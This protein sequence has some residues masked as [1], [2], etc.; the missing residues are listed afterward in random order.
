MIYTVLN[1]VF[2]GGIHV[3]G[4]TANFTLFCRSAD[5][6]TAV[7]HDVL[8]RRAISNHAEKANITSSR[9]NFQILNC[10]IVAVIGSAERGIDTDR[11]KLYTGHVDFGSLFPILLGKARRIL[12]IFRAELQQ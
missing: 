2:P 8:D 5:C 4:N 1:R 3:T 6:T 11:R 12:V 7:Q 10:K 9:V